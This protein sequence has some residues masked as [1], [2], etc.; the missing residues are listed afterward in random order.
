M[1]E[2]EKLDLEILKSSIQME[3]LHCFSY[4][5]FLSKA[6]PESL[7]TSGYR[8]VS[9]AEAMAQAFKTYVARIEK[10]TKDHVKKYPDAR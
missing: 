4:L 5:L 2:Q 3:K 6:T 1:T 7:V 10:L 8:N 9:N